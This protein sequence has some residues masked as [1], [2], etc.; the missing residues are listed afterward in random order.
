[1][2]VL[3]FAL[4]Q[5]FDLEGEI[6]KEKMRGTI[7]KK[8]ILA[9]VLFLAAITAIVGCLG[10]CSGNKNY[11]SVEVNGK[12]MKAH[13]DGSGDKTIVMLSRRDSDSPEDDFLPLFHRL[14]EIY[15]ENC[16]IVILNYFGYGNSD[17]TNQ[18]RTN[19]NMVQEIRT[20]LN[21]LNIDPPYILMPHEIS[22]LYSLYYANKYP[23]EVSAIVGLDMSLPQE[24]LERWT[25]ETFEET[26]FD[27]NLTKSNINHMNHWISFY[28]NSKELENVK[29]PA[30]LP[31]L[32]IISEKH[33]DN[34]NNMITSGDI[35]TSLIEM[36]NN[37]ITNPKL[38]ITR[39]LSGG[40][41]LTYDQPDEIVKASTEFIG[42]L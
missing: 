7:V 41:D 18:D 11:K 3:R 30:N 32:S 28:R 4:D 17:T 25:E 37:M 6:F 35:K 9:K 27:K 21:K 15:K 12:I 34:V 36:N 2:P 31:V 16:K 23:S 29:Y 38:Q 22:G 10:G 42:N 19:E 20:A 1:M 14:H 5:A 13:V 8:S 24:Q 40:G 39:I 33:I 26:K